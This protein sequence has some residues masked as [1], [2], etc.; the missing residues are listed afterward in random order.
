MQ[1]NYLPVVWLLGR[2]NGEKRAC[3]K[4]KWAAPVGSQ[5]A[6]RTEIFPGDTNCSKGATNEN[7]VVTPQPL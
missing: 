2:L 4:I 3:F 7:S 6:R 1:S 5:S